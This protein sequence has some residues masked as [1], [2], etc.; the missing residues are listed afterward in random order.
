[1]IIFEVYIINDDYNF[2]KLKMCFRAISNRLPF[3]T[4]MIKNFY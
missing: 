4:K 3:F 2:Y 1:M